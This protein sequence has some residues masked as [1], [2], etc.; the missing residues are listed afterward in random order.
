MKKKRQKKNSAYLW[1]RVFEIASLFIVGLSWGWY[2]KPPVDETINLWLVLSTVLVAMS[3]ITTLV[4]EIHHKG[5]K[6]D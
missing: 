3:H 2:L 5:G 4:L 6:D 1:W